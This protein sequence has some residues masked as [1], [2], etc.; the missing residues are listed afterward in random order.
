MK[1]KKFF[2]LLKH[3]MFLFAVRSMNAVLHVLSIRHRDIM[4]EK[5]MT[6]ETKMILLKNN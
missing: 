6:I 5:K 3:L 4:T 2:D 1:C